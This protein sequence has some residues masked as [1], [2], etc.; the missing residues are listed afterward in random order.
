MPAHKNPAI[1]FHWRNCSGCD[2]LQG[3]VKF[4]L[5]DS[6]TILGWMTVLRNKSMPA[7]K[8]PAV[9]FQWKDTSS[10][11]FLQG[12]AKFSLKDRI[13]IL[14]WRTMLRNKIFACTHK[15]CY[16]ISLEK[17]Q[18]VWFLARIGR[19]QCQGQYHY[20]GLYVSAEEQN[21]CLHTKI[22]LFY[23]NG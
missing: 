5:K 14:S 22:L 8:N 15:S 3:I 11:D 1:L 9:L 17:L 10:C 20:P 7:C 12:M 4:S 19:I 21:L 13:T 18:W 16:F 23:F 6:I 2:F